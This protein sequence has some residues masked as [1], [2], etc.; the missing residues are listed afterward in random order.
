M[1]TWQTSFLGH[2]PPPVPRGRRA[3]MAVGTSGAVAAAL[4]LL[5]GAGL[6]SLGW[7]RPELPTEAS[8]PAPRLPELREQLA[9]Q[10]FCTPCLEPEPCLAQA[11]VDWAGL[12]LLFVFGVVVGS[13]LTA[14]CCT[15][16]L[17]GASIFCRQRAEPLRSLNRPIPAGAIAW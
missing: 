7:R 11:P 3:R 15:G 17:A 8:P 16:A 4:Y 14:C 10:L 1:C 5:A 12:V 2:A 9:Q 13:I 6:A